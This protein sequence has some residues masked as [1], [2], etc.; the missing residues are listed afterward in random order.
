M[1]MRVTSL[2]EHLDTPQAEQNR[3]EALS[4]ATAEQ[5]QAMTHLEDYRALAAIGLRHRPRRIFEIGTFLGITSNFL[6][7][8]L[9]E[10]QVVSI[11]YVNQKWN[12]F[13]S[14]YNNSSLQMREIGSQVRP[15][16]RPRFRQLYGDSH[17]LQAET[18]IRKFGQ[19]D[20]IF[21][22]GDHTYQGVKQDTELCLQLLAPGGALCW[23]DANPCEKY[24]D[25][26]N[27]LEQECPLPIVA[28]TDHYI[29]GVAYH[30]D[31]RL[32][33]TQRAA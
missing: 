10:T 21:I 16:N 22:D 33:S 24:L 15:K 2:F 18:L 31:Q 14:R 32:V 8:L 29:G 3:A 13:R 9:P 27:Y 5:A 17:Q 23:H 25:V 7:E 26:R 11:A 4:Q 6:L 12:L 1:F 30:H 20:M 19:F 28:T